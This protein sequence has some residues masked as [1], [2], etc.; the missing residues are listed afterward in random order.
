[1]FLYQKNKYGYETVSGHQAANV[2]QNYSASNLDAKISNLYANLFAKVINF[3]CKII[4]SIH[5]KY[6]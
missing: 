1:M 6:C 2:K 4:N 3:A 5:V